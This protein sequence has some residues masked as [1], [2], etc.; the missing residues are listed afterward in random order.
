MS[1]KPKSLAYGDTSLSVPAPVHQPRLSTGRYP[2]CPLCG[3]AANKAHLRGKK[4]I[5]KAAQ[6]PNRFAGRQVG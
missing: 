3:V 2:I 6:I 5:E 4:H 1:A